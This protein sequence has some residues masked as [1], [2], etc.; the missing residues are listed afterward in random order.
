MKYW[1]SGIVVLATLLIASSGFAKEPAFALPAD[2]KGKTVLY[3]GAHPDDEWGI[4]PV[5]AEACIERRAHCR[6]IVVSESN[7]LGCLL[8]IGLRDAKECSKR[9]RA[10]MRKVAKL[11]KGSVEFLGFDDLFFAFNDAGVGRVMD[12]W[13]SSAGGNKALVAKMSAAVR[14]ANP[15]VV[16]TFDPR[17]GSSCHSGHRAAAKLALEAIR[18]LPAPKRPMVWLEQTSDLEEHGAEATSVIEA[19]GY[20]GWPETAG[21]TLHYDARHRLPDGRTAFDVMVEERKLHSSQMPDEASGKRVINPP[22]ALR[23]V[24]LSA[25][26]E[27]IEA[28]FCTSLDLQRPTLD[29]EAGKALVEQLMKA[30]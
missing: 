19:G 24:P 2:I 1:L 9:R 14:R 16:F 13:R 27:D 5:L 15:S 30:N 25:M 8:T 20:F 10:E 6:F 18:Q 4:A 28:D 21:Q 12:G 17:H 11:F 3:I 7:S 29:T 26:P 22:D 23:F